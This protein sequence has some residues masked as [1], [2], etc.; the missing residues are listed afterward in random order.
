MLLGTI[1]YTI[2]GKLQYLANF[3]SLRCQIS[4]IL[5]IIIII[6][7]IIILVVVAAAAAVGTLFLEV[8]C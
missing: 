3:W 4:Q 6:I 8:L 7:I 2:S 5:L 1:R